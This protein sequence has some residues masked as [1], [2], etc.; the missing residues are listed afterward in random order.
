MTAL[1]GRIVLVTGAAGGIGRRMALKAAQ[2]GA[3]VVV[4]DIDGDRLD[5][6]VNSRVVTASSFDVG[7][8]ERTKAAVPAVSAAARAVPWALA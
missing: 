3:T 6:V 8:A 5:V 7:N 2:G 1:P 4:W